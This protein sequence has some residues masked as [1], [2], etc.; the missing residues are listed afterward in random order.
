MK[1]TILAAVAVFSLSVAIAQTKS[2]SIIPIPA[3]LISESGKFVLTNQVAISVSANEA[4]K[5]VAH[6]LA[7]QIAQSTGFKL[8]VNPSIQE[9]GIRLQLLAKTN[10]NLGTEGYLLKVTEKTVTISANQAAGLFMACKPYCNYYPMKL[11]AKK[12]NQKLLGLFLV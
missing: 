3:S 11:K 4:A 12:F 2:P 9:T 7:Q 1:K 8:A 6:Q 5:Q 10:A